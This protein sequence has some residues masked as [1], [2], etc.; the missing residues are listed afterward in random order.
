MPYLL[1]FLTMPVQVDKQ[2]VTPLLGFVAN[3]SH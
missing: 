3:T 1:E 2:C